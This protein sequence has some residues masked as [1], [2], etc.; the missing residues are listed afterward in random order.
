MGREGCEG[1]LPEDI[2]SIL[3]NWDKKSESALYREVR[4]KNRVFGETIHL[5]PQFH[6][7]RVYA[8]DITE[9]KQADEAVHTTLQRFYTVLSSMYTALLLVTDES[10]VEFANQAL[11]D[12]FDLTD[13]PADCGA[14]SS[15]IFAK[16]SKAYLHPDE[17]IA[18]IKEIV[19]RGQPVKG[20]EVAMRNGREFLRDFIPVHVNGKSYGRLWHHTDIT[21]RKHV[22]EE[23]RK[24]RDELELRVQERTEE[25]Q[26]CLRE[27]EGGDRGARAGRS[28]APPGPEDGGPRHALA[29]ASP[30][31]STTSLRPSSASRSWW[32]TTR[33]WGAGMNATWRGSW[34]QASGAGNW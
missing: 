7:A 25:L 15:E 2:G 3:Q 29:A 28:P 16:I 31:T 23:L 8:L 11:C 21:E 17:A 5:V 30:T 32:R 22:E 9:R 10:R 13:S 14:H 12:Y 24:S 20:E 26:R 6:V 4:L 19:G 27:T 1:F 33:P 34:R 18:R